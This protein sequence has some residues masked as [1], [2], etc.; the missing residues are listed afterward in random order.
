[1]KTKLIKA[2]KHYSFGNRKENILPQLPNKAS[3]LNTHLF[4]YF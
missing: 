1:M 2:Y 4:R 3:N